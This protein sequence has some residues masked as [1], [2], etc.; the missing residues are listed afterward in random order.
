MVGLT[1]ETVSQ[2]LARF[3]E[4]GLM[5]PPSQCQVTNHRREALEDRAVQKEAGNGVLAD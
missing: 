1:I 2:Q 4:D 3:R 5:D